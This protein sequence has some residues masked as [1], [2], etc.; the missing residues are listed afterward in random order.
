M[1]GNLTA[2]IQDHQPGTAEAAAQAAAETA[3]TPVL[4]IT[5]KQ[6][7]EILDLLGD[8]DSIPLK[9]AL[10]GTGETVATLRLERA[11]LNIPH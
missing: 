2:I 10:R 5:R 8:S 1:V 9:L 7:D 6:L 11:A 4:D 3:R